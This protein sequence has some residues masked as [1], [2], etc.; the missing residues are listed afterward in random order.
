MQ[1]KGIM[2]LAHNFLQLL[3]ILTPNDLQCHTENGTHTHYDKLDYPS[4]AQINKKAK[5]EN[6]FLVFA[7]VGV[8]L[9]LYKQLARR[10][11]GANAVEL[12]KESDNVVQ[13]I[14]SEYQKIKSTLQI[15]QEPTRIE[16]LEITYTFLCDNQ[17]KQNSNG[18]AEC[19]ITA[20]AKKE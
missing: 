17:T 1:S 16:G 12:T 10:I 6:V 11:Q 2:Y 4:I 18:S 7:V 19:Q 14:S 13:I 15:R 5:E 3:G 20:E 8:Q 9:P